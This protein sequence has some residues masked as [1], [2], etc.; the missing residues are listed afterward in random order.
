M[1]RT[2]GGSA[3]VLAPP[4]SHARPARQLIDDLS[5]R[6]RTRLCL[7]S[8]W[9]RS[10]VQSSIIRLRSIYGSSLLFS[11]SINMTSSRSGQVRG[12][13]HNSAIWK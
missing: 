6:A 11:K 13:P 3:S 10:T 2:E 1:I 8:S 7:R 9:P 4:P 5:M 12:R